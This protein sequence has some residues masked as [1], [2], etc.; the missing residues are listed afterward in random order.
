M[1]ANIIIINVGTT[2]DCDGT[3]V[4]DIV[5]EDT[6]QIKVRHKHADI[7]SLP[8]GNQRTSQSLKSMP[9]YIRIICNVL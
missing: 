2:T 1:I 3:S 5:G 6:N 8:Y 9:K 7:I 4:L